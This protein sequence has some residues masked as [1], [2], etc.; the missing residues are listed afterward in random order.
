MIKSLMGRLLVWLY[1]KV[2]KKIYYEQSRIH[3]HKFAKCGDNVRF[4]GNSWISGHNFI[5]I[6]NN[7]VA[8][9][10]FRLE[11]IDEYCGKQYNPKIEIGNNVC[12]GENCHI[13]AIEHIKIGNNALF[14]SKV[15]LT[16]HLHGSIDNR[17]INIPPIDRPLFSSPIVIG[18]N[19]W[20]GEGTSILKGVTLGDNVIVGA[21]SVVT[22]SFK[23]NCVIAGVPAKIIKNLTD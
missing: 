17:D 2:K 12:F 7:V 3:C 1:L 19:C 23:S 21:N 22:H 5:S 10:N 11:A 18:D 4:L 9:D 6:D 20:I 13:G 8:G 16:D 14:A 15:L